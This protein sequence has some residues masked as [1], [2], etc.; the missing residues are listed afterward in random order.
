M[1]GLPSTAMNENVN[2]R[3]AALAIILAEHAALAAVLMSMTALVTEAQRRCRTPD[4]DALRAM[5][6]YVGE[7]PERRHH[8]KETR[9]LFSRL[10]EVAPDAHAV[11][12]RLDHEHA[13]G[14]GRVRALEHE[15]TAWQVLGEA[16]RTRFER[17][18]DAYASFY[19]AH[20][21]LEET[22]V[23][24]LAERVF[25]DDDWRMVARAFGF[26]RD[27][28]TGAHP[29]AVYAR[30]FDTIIKAMPATLRPRPVADVAAPP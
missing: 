24:P 4:F 25:G 17:A 10:R 28:L 7:F 30:L 15:L 21:R 6:F 13:Q 18:L 3:R 29:D 19:L 16:R 20:M 5:L 2:G 27:A 26:H 9:M 14:E 23:L 12:D 11:L 22:E 1:P 8:V